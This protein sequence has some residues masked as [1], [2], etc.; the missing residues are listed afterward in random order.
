M[1][2]EIDAE[3]WWIG[4]FDCIAKQMKALR[5]AGNEPKDIIRIRIDGTSGSRAD[6]R[7][8]L[9]RHPSKDELIG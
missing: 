3:G 5:M 8:N 4:A 9:V 6:V 1:A 2:D 7:M